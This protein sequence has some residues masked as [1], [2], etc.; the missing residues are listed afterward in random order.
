MDLC[1]F[2]LVALASGA[3]QLN[4]V[5]HYGA[6]E[7]HVDPVHTVRGAAH[8]G[9]PQLYARA[10]PVIEGARNGAQTF[11]DEH[12]SVPAIHAD[13]YGYVPDAYEYVQDGYQHSISDFHANA[14]GY[15][16]GTKVQ[17]YGYGNDAHYNAHGVH[18]PAYHTAPANYKGYGP[19][20]Q[21][22]NV[23][24]TPVHQAASF[25]HAARPVVLTPVH[26]SAPVHHAAPVFHA[27]PVVHAPVYHA[28]PVQYN[29]V[30]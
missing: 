20:Y 23:V 22:T 16:H 19:V 17:A 27:T 18:A 24:P 30:H 12:H 6:P 4:E 29:A 14:N 11:Y 25:Y 15:G 1:I 8:Y 5:A 21:A 28:A 9:G 3:P 13:P 2:G 10:D 7:L 26:H